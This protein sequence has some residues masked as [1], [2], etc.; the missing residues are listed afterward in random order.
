VE[1]PAIDVFNFGLDTGR[2]VEKFPEA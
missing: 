2:V 1:P